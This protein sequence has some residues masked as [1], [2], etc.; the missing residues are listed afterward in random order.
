[1][2]QRRDNYEMLLKLRRTARNV[3]VRL[4][5][6]FVQNVLHTKM[7][8]ILVEWLFKSL[9]KIRNHL[10]KAPQMK[11]DPSGVGWWILFIYIYD[12]FKK[13]WWVGFK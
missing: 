12:L 6:F 10:T 1:M 7:K 11:V 2:T 9:I 3:V 5:S 8:I 13:G 4:S